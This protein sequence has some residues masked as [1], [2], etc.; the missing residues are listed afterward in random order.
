V[1]VKAKYTPDSIAVRSAS[2]SEVWPSVSTECVTSHLPCAVT[3]LFQSLVKLIA[4][5]VVTC[6]KEE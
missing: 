4:A 2:V 6:G 1:C 3:R 5:A